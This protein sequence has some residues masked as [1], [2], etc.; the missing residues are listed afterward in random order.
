MNIDL[1][2]AQMTP[3]AAAS[4]IYHIL[5]LFGALIAIAFGI[6]GAVMILRDHLV[7]GWILVG[8]G[9]MALIGPIVMQAFNTVT[10]SN[11]NFN[12]GG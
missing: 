5:V 10:G 8:I 7:I 9:I 3:D 4:W 11:L 2:L 6:F 1:F 12:A